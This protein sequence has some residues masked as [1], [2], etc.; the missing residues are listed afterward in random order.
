MTKADYG[1]KPIIGSLLCIISYISTLEERFN[2]R[3]LE[4]TLTFVGMRTLFICSQTH[5][6]VFVFLNAMI[7]SFEIHSRSLMAKDFCL[8]PNILS[9]SIFYICC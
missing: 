1:A 7:V 5:N 3:L 4:T 6:N 8:A 2:H 9:A